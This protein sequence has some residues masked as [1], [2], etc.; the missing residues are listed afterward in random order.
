MRAA[1]DGAATGGAPAPAGRARYR[2]SNVDAALAG[3]L[4][5]VDGATGDL[6]FRHPLVRSA[7]LQSATPNERRAAHAELARLHREDIERQAAHPAKLLGAGLGRAAVAIGPAQIKGV[8]ALPPAQPRAGF[9]VLG[10]PANRRRAVSLTAAQFR[11]GLGNA[12][13]PAVSDDLHA[14]LTIPSPGRPLFQAAFANFAR[15]SPAAVATDNTD[16]C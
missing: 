1:L 16:R 5:T 11:Y 12:L 15:R 10:N 6:V 14:R 8:K 2:M 9:P 4:L 3:G 13:P 7:L